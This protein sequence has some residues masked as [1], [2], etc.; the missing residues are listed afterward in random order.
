MGAIGTGAATASA[1]PKIWSLLRRKV[2][3]PRARR[4]DVWAFLGLSAVTLYLF[5]AA[6]FGGRVLFRRDINMVWLPQVEV[7]VRCVAS[8]SWP[9]WDP[10]TGFGR[11]LLA[12]PRAEVLYPLTWLNLLLSPGTYYTLFVVVH[13]VFSGL[14]VFALARRWQVFP[15]G[16]FVA[17][18]VWIGSGPFLSLVAMWHHLAGAAWIPW[19][20]LAA[21]VAL[22]SGRASHALLWGAAM[23]AQIFAGSPDYTVLTLVALAP[24]VLWTAVRGRTLPTAIPVLGLTG[25]ALGFALALSAAQWLPTLDWALRSDRPAQAYAART[26]WSLHPAAL[27]EVLFP[28]RWI[29]FPL[30]P[31]AKARILD[32]KEPWLYSIYLGAPALALAAAGLASS[33]PRRWFLAAVAA[34]AVLLSLGRHGAVYDVFA[35]LVPPLRMLR[36]P[37][38]AMVLAAFSWSLLAGRG[39]DVWRRR[40]PCSNRLWLLAVVTPA[41]ALLVL[42]LAGSLASTYGAD[43]WGPLVLERDAFGSCAVWLALAAKAF[44]LSACLCGGVLLLALVRRQGLGAAAWGAGA[45]AVLA[46]GHLLMFHRDLHT[47]APRELL[48]LRPEVLPL[49]ERSEFP[50]LY[51]Y[52]YS[53]IKEEERQTNPG[54]SSSYRVA[55]LPAGWTAAETLVLAVHLY[56]NPPTAARWGLFG[57]YDRDIL[58]FE[59]VPLARLDALLREMEDTPIHLRLLRMGSVTHALALVRGVWWKDLVPVASFQEFLERPIHVFEVPDPLPRS[60]VVGGVRVA[61]GTEALAVL[62]DPGFDPTREIVLPEGVPRR[63]QARQPGTSRILAMKPDRVRI[64]A[65]LDEPG[66]VVLVDGYDPG[67][68]ATVD[69]QQA[70]V[71]RANVAFR[72]VHVAPGKHVVEFV[73]RPRTVAAGLLASAA[74]AAAATALVWSARRSRPGAV[75]GQRRA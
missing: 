36:Y 8:G 22:D 71:L 26:T 42:S 53:M 27:L 29:N 39:F 56:L 59:P 19:I 73:Y 10:Y 41:A 46:V 58:S 45:L 24:Y 64:Q 55:R 66:Y 4:E 47:T 11:P 49:L 25:L 12:D 28:V 69:S 35:F 72:A 62:A 60:Y 37:V 38:K 2:R 14:G 40:E 52:D 31:E 9:L 18:A 50:R 67:W 33:Q 54:A 51:V 68:H 23:A 20:F 7:F 1:A 17:A 13:L 63:A 15:A 75:P 48:T 70:T 30:L 61:D 57:S 3:L 65:D 34:A 16:A 74:A 32:S 5:R 6:V 21:D 43:R 44:V